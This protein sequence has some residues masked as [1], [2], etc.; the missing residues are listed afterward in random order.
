M[1]SHIPQAAKQLSMP[2]LLIAAPHSGAGKTIVALGLMAALARR[3]L[4]VQPFKAGPDFIDPGLHRLVTGRESHNLDCRMCGENFVKACYARY[5]TGAEITVVEGVMGLFD[6][7]EGSSANLARVLGLP[8]VLVVDASSM[9]ES[10]A[11]LVKGFES[12]DPGLRLVGVILNRVGSAR[13]LK[14]LS[15]AIAGH[16]RAEVLGSLQREVAF[17]IPERHLGLHQGEESPLGDKALATL[18]KAVAEGIDLDR[19][20]AL[21]AG[22]WPMPVDD[23]A[24]AD[25]VDGGKPVRIGVA[26]DAAFSF[27]YAENLRLLVAA[28]AELVEFSP[29]ADPCLPPGIAGLYLGGGYP[30]LYA[31]LLAANRP[32]RQAIRAWSQAGRPLYAECGGFMY[33]TE[34]IIDFSGCAWPMAGVFPVAARMRQGRAALGYRRATLT[35]ATPLGQKGTE[36]RGHEFHYS[37]I[38][39]MPGEIRRS[40]T[41]AEGGEEGYLINGRTLGGYLHLH[42]GGSPWAATHFV[43]VCRE[44]RA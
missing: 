44:H 12:L 16:C 17:A 29:L 11:A 32:M 23:A 13:H 14:M 2:G 27:Y 6:G 21:A 33:L 30:E 41:L 43:R 35:A 25:L 37:E 31:E 38:E 28:G 8:V 42:F 36:L 1:I 40:Y 10:A 39:P 3:G 22:S 7:G 20:L 18:V 24:L 34:K 9:A 4:N 26:R 19:L 15:E 5:A